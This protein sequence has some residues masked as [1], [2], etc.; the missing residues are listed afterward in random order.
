M[1]DLAACGAFACEARHACYRYRVP[2]GPWQT[3][4]RFSPSGPEGCDRRIPVEAGDRVVP[5]AEADARAR[6]ATV[7]RRM[8]LDGA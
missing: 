5:E 3:F 2:W 1:A 8:R 6:K 4:A 7:F